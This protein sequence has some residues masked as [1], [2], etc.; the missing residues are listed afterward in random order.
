MKYE[1]NKND[2][3][4]LLERIKDIQA[5][6]ESDKY[7]IDLKAK[8]R[9][10][11]QLQLY[12]GGWLPAILYFLKDDIK[13]HTTEELHIYLKEYYC[14]S[15]NKSEYFKQVEIMGKKRY[16]CIFSINFEKCKQEIFNDYMDFVSNDFY[17]LINIDISDID[18]LMTEYKKATTIVSSI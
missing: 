1:L 2:L 12:W 8:D 9:S 18:N 13:L 11:N 15:K 17:H 5:K 14:Y 4:K 7:Y 3:N 10:Y 6:N 16:I